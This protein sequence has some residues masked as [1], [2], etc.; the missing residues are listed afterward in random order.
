[1]TLQH[2]ENFLDAM[3]ISN[4]NATAQKALQLFKNSA[5]GELPTVDEWWQVMY[6]EK[7]LAG[8]IS[9]L[10]SFDYAVAQDLETKED[11]LQAITQ[12]LNA[13]LSIVQ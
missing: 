8:W 1:M 9:A 2:H 5:G 3:S 10:R 7:P 4:H 6:C 13:D 12:I 11:V